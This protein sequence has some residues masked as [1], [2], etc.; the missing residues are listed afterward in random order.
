MNNHLLNIFKLGLE[1]GQK[2]FEELINENPWM[3]NDICRPSWGHIRRCAMNL[4][5]EE[6]SKDNSFLLKKELIKVNSA[7]QYP[8]YYYD[9]FKVTINN[10]RALNKLPR[11]ANHRREL[12]KINSHVYS[13]QYDLFTPEITN[14]NYY[15]GLVVFGGKNF[16]LDFMGFQIPDENYQQIKKIYNLNSI[17]SKP[18]IDK[19]INQE[20][21]KIKLKN[22][23][24]ERIKKIE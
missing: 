17:I 21:I 13:Q 24:E 1:G 2:I 9:D 23:V 3:K 12:S 6:L 8:L 11:T 7:Y 5:I 22:N 20:E 19:K 15:Y 4:S 14:S 10:T 16:K 18:L